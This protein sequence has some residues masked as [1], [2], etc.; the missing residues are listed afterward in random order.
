MKKVEIIII[1]NIWVSKGR[2]NQISTN[3]ILKTLKSISIQEFQLPKIITQWIICL[4]S[5][6]CLLWLGWF[7]LLVCLWREKFVELKFIIWRFS[8]FDWLWLTSDSGRYRCWIQLIKRQIH[9]ILWSYWNYW[10][11]K[12]MMDDSKCSFG[13]SLGLNHQRN[14]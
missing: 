7:G 13:S 12:N 5:W 8:S 10:N 14:P 6:F 11:M 1:E 9:S 4:P 2:T 3:N